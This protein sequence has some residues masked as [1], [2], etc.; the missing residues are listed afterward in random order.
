MAADYPRLDLHGLPSCRPA[1]G[2]VP[3]GPP[4]DHRPALNLNRP[5]Q[6]GHRVDRIRRERDDHVVQRPVR[7]LVMPQAHRQPGARPGNTEREDH[8]QRPNR[9]RQAY[10]RHRSREQLPAPI[11]G[12]QFLRHAHVAAVAEARRDALRDLELVSRAADRRSPAGG[13]RHLQVATPKQGRAPQPDTASPGQ[14]DPPAGHWHR[15]AS[16]CRSRRPAGRGTATAATSA[17]PASPCWPDTQPDRH[18]SVAAS[19]TIAVPT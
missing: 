5:A 14:P 8:R 15:S 16:N 7:E 1:A 17:A 19:S 11:R 18:G 9:Q 4:R 2:G 12:D 3:D 13:E 6:P 10:S